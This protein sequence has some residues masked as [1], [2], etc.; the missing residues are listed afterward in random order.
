MNKIT[1]TITTL[2]VAGLFGAQAFAADVSVPRY[3]TTNTTWTKNNVYIL[4]G[5]TFVINNVTLT[6]EPGTVIKGAE[7]VVATDAA[8]LVIAQGSKIMAEGTAAEPI[9][10]TSVLDNP[11]GAGTDANIGLWGG[12]VVLGKAQINSRADGQAPA[13]SPVTDQIEGFSVST[14]EVPYITFGGADDA[15][16]SGVIKYVSI[17][18]GGVALSTSNE[19]NGLTMGG[20]GS[21]TSVSWVEVFANK[22]D[23][24]EWFGGAVSGKWLVSAFCNDEG[25]DWDTGWRGNLQHIFAI[26]KDVT[27]DRADNGAEMDG[28]TRDKDTATPFQTTVVYNATYIGIGTSSNNTNRALSF[29]DNTS[30]KYYNSIFLDFAR[31][32]FAEAV[33]NVPAQVASAKIDMSNNIFWSHLGAN[34]TAAGMLDSAV[35]DVTLRANLEAWFTNADKEN[36]IVNPMLTGVNRTAGSKGLDPRPMAASPALAGFRS[37]PD[38]GFFTQANYRGAFNPFGDLWIKGWTKLDQAGY[39]SDAE[40]PSPIAIT[41]L[42]SVSTRGKNDVGVAEEFNV[43]FAIRG[44]ATVSVVARA[45]G[46][47]GLGAA[48]EG[49]GAVLLANPNITVRKLTDGNGVPVPTEM[50]I[51]GTNDNWNQDP[52]V[53]MLTGTSLDPTTGSLPLGANDSSL[54]LEN[55]A[56]GNYTVQILGGSGI[57][58]GEVYSVDLN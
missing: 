30:S 49:T 41:E 39:L 14:G 36:N 1:Q 24:F 21:G 15:D 38:D 23:G 12:V 27:T 56:P 11:V 40:A 26:G 52:K 43:G 35:T 53:G 6:I 46:A 10:F 3:I 20:V 58:L 34:N 28:A 17:R 18:H 8:A 22:D 2:A 5:Y 50:Q 9:I 42:I 16:N 47:G 29:N 54:V 25:F 31:M 32:I 4:Q 7:K 51:I 48:F 37:V 13:G 57:V 55:L 44:D 19:I 45:V 33:D